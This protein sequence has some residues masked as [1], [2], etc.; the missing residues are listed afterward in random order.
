M[1]EQGSSRQYFVGGNWKSNGTLQFVKETIEGV[2]NKVEYNQDRVRKS[3][4]LNL[5]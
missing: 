1:V 3:N 2:L 5:N 4:F